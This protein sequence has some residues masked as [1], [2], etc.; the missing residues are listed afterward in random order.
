MLKIDL[1]IHTTHSGHAYA[2][3]YE[4]MKEAKSKGME[5]IAIT[6]HGPSMGSTSIAHFL[7]ADRSPKTYEGMEVLWGCEANIINGKGDIDLNDAAIKKLD[8]IL[9]GLHMGT[10]YKDLGKKKNTE[11]IINCFKRYPIHIFTHPATLFYDYDVE[12]VFQAACDNDI[13]LELNM[14][15]LVNLDRGFKNITLENFRKIVDV[16]KKN[17]RKLIINSDTHFLSELGNDDI[18]RKYW[19]KLG[20]NDTIIMNNYPD[21]LRAFIKGKNLP[22]YSPEINKRKK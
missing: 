12:K 13:L 9:V 7:I 3:I 21:E 2:T 19:D 1:H 11:A 8:I 22:K 17:K 18:L 5:M 6:D 16:T 4:I 10:P 15:N 14:T 20:L